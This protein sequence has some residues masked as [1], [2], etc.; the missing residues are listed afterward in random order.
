MADTDLP[1]V[2]AL[3]RRPHRQGHRAG[4]GD[5]RTR[6]RGRRLTPPP[7]PSPARGDHAPWRCE[8]RVGYCRARAAPVLVYATGPG[9][10]GGRSAAL[11]IDHPEPDGPARGDDGRVRSLR[12][13]PPS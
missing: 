5:L 8:V 11:T 1:P 10:V 13:R 4:R 6:L 3:G 2:D 9:R 12:G 7:R